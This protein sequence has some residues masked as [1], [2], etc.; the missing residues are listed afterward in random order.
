MSPSA[1]YT[2]GY[3]GVSM[4]HFLDLL[5]AAGVQTVVD[6]R[7]NP[8]SRKAGFSKKPLSEAVEGAGL[9]YV[10]WRA[11]GAPKPIRD[12]YKSSNDWRD[13]TRGFLEHL[14]AQLWEVAKLTELANRETV[15]L[16]CYEAD[17]NRCHRRYVA[18]AVQAAGGPVVVHLSAQA[19]Q[20]SLPL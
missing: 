14:D 18:D 7:D 4:D 16:V 2:L 19:A 9:K 15:C 20:S 11:L 17:P 10:S 3:E 1:I 6:V 12:A 8:Y 13:Y 5:Q